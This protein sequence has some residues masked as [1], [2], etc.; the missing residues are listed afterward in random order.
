VVVADVSGKGVAA[1]LLMPSIEVAL[2]MDAARFSSTSDLLQLFNK[3]RLPGD[4]RASVYFAVLWKALPTVG[5]LGIYKRG[6][7]SAA[8]DS[9]RHGSESTRQR[10]PSSGCAPEFRT[11]RVRRSLSARET[12]SFCT[13]MVRSKLRIQQA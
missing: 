3:R 5:F 10:R 8:A 1:G 2:R 12:F 6:A 4:E 9:R 7:Q 11:T 13:P